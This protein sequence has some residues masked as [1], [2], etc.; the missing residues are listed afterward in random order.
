MSD[1][2]NEEDEIYPAGKLTSKRPAIAVHAAKTNVLRETAM[3]V[4]VG[5][6]SMMDDIPKVA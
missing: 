5:I 2:E 3:I 1:S 6:W 4:V